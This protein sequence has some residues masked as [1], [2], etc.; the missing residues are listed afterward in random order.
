MF[1]TLSKGIG[2]RLRQRIEDFVVEEIWN[3]KQQKNG[4]HTIF[5]L[6]KFNWDTHLALR[7]IAKKLHISAK[8]F[9][10]A[11][12]KDKRAVTKQKVSL[13]DPKNELLEKL[14]AITIKDIKLSGFERGSRI[15]LGNSNGNRFVITIRD[16]DMPEEKIRQ[17][18]AE[19]FSDLSCGIPNLFGPQRFGEVRAI[20]SLVGREMLNGNFESAVQIYL[21]KIF[22]EETD[23]S[24]AARSFLE[25]EWNKP[26]KYSQAILLF[27]MRLRYE[28]AMIGYLIKFPKDFAGAMRRLPLRLRKMFLNAVQAEVWNK[29]V[30]DLWQ[31][32]NKLRQQKIPLIGFDTILNNK[33]KIHKRIIDVMNDIGIRQK[34]FLM[35]C[36][37]ELR[38]S[39]S[40]RFLLLKPK[41]MKIIKISDD[42]YNQGKKA[43]QIAFELPAGSYAT[44]VLR[45]ILKVEE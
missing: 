7:A 15:R 41:K 45:E 13:W 9:S 24:K 10:I 3:E 35:K 1:F 18:L 12:T 26:E 22:E 17:N 23:D 5:I 6:E 29:V 36:M 32:K 20:T 33:N 28:R 42:E 40:E 34:Y 37:P 4:E 27:P 43:V 38:C 2:G 8:R 16:I 44:V 19:L 31:E 21:C 39:G 11:G 14:K 30:E 25:K